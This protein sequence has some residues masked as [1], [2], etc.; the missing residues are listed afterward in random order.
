MLKKLF[1][2][3]AAA[4]AVSVP[5]AG[6]AWADPPSDPGSNGKGIGQ[7][8]VPTRAGNVLDSIPTPPGAPS[9]NPNPGQPVTPGSV[10][11]GV[12]QNPNLPNKVPDAFGQTLTGFWSVYPL[13]GSDPGS[14]PANLVVGSTPPGLGT[15]VFTPG[16]SHGH[17]ATSQPPTSG[18]L[19]PARVMGPPVCHEHGTG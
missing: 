12:A 14:A 13:P 9:A 8:G 16:C 6:M 11:K 15:K 4:A 2:T 5:L 18:C 3:A 17:V 7:G 19:S 10:V 1:V